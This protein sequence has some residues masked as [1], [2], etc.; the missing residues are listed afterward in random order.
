MTGNDVGDVDSGANDLQNF[1]ALASAASSG[2]NTTI[3]GTLNSAA[4]TTFNI[5]FYSSPTA[6][7]SGFGEGEVYL[8]SDVVVTDGS[9][10]AT[11]N[12][13][14][15]GVSVTGGHV[16]SATAT[17]L[18]GSTSEFSVAVTVMAPNPVLDLDANNSSGQT[19]ADFAVAWTEDGPPVN[20]ADADASLFD[21]DS[22][23]F[24]SLTVTITNLLDGA[25]ELLSAS[26]GGT[27]I[28]AS[29]NSTTG[30]L[31][32]TG[33]DTVA[34]YQQVLRSVTYDNMLQDPNTTARVIAFVASDGT[35]SSNIGTTTVTLNE[36][37]DAPVVT[38]PGSALN[39]TEQVGLAL[40][41]TGFSVGDVDGA[42][43]GALATLTVGEGAIA[44][45]AGNSGVSIT[46][47]NATGTVTLTGSSTQLN[48]LLTGGGTGTITYLNGSDTPSAS[49]TF[50]V[51]VNDQGNT[52]AGGP[53]SA[54]AVV[55][56]NVAAVN[57]APQ[58]D[59]DANN[60]SGQTGANFANT[61]TEDGGPIRVADSDATLTDVDSAMLVSL[62]VVL[63][64]QFDGVNEILAADT[65][66]TS[67]TVNYNAGVLT[68]SGVDSV[69]NYQQ[70]LRTVTYQNLSQNPN[71]TARTIEF[72]AS[73]GIASSNLATA[74]VE[75]VRQNDAP[76][77]VSES[78]SVDNNKTLTVTIPGLLTNDSD[79]DNDPLSVALVSGPAS[80]TLVLNSNG[81]FSYVPN[82][83]F[84]GR[85]SFTYVAT[86]GSLNSA[87]TTVWID[88]VAVAAPPI[89]TPPPTDPSP[90]PGP[91]PQ[92]PEDQH[93]PNQPPASPNDPDPVD[94]AT[95]NGSPGSTSSGGSNST[96]TLVIAPQESVFATLD[97][98]AQSAK[99]LIVEAFR[100]GEA[101]LSNRTDHSRYEVT[102]VQKFGSVDLAAPISEYELA[103]LQQAVLWQ[104]LDT[105]QEQLESDSD[106]LDHIAGSATVVTAA[107]STGYVIWTLRGSFL[108][109]SFLSTV[110]TWRSLDPLPIIESN[111][112]TEADGGDNE[113]L[114]DIAQSGMQGS[115]A[116]SDESSTT[117]L[118]GTTAR[119]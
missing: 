2:G 86:D 57:D 89:V 67:I 16:I 5:D 110:P 21:P 48:N 61:F 92:Q 112:G 76:V 56:I 105:L 47:G 72:V 100:A 65:A 38:A 87:P 88:V 8:G 29:Y 58:T 81:S 111:Q 23:T 15:I 22:L 113:S 33:V 9:G 44:V 45:V 42:G 84:S 53:L 40:H 4:S 10:N 59:L 119:D 114:A 51:T 12:T 25:A 49:T 85:T 6:D 64:N 13:T 77:S 97:D 35:N 39:A 73:D 109:A 60:S 11:I 30:V 28:S 80:G 14:L 41:G 108:L 27:S 69:A 118:T 78:Y 79:V 96:L 117:N 74:T 20:I 116:S 37:N 94:D 98:D 7:G 101:K 46:G 95:G 106:R 83:N 115:T 55:V 91:S 107:L 50:A 71:T 93:P 75:V 43:G 82:L 62:Q 63:M 36:V 103:E 34:N 1:P 52:G 90:A 68:L 70:V 18:S 54:N 102:E 24:N 32:L 17:T 104:Q 66:G 99:Q 26:T 31:S 19:S 3:L